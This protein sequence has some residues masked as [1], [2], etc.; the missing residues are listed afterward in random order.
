[1]KTRYFLTPVLLVMI[2]SEGFS[3][4]VT[5]KE[6]R[7]AENEI[8]SQQIEM[9]LNSGKF[10]FKAGYAVPG[11]GRPINMAGNP[12]YVI[13]NKEKMEGDLPFFGTATAGIGLSGDLAIKFRNKPQTFTTKKLKK[14]YDI[15]VI[16]RGD[17]GTYNLS[18][19][20]PFDGQSTLTVSSS[21]RGTIAYNGEVFQLNEPASQQKPDERR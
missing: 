13:F 11:G 14:S 19:Y 18:L 5:K 15:E 16:V 10:I 12:G 2:L 1:M 21:N 3:Q 8:K 17:N 9:L 20:I 6:R 7:A 4:T